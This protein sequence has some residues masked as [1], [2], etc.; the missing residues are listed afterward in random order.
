MVTNNFDSFSLL[1]LSRVIVAL[2]TT[3]QKHINF[4]DSKLTRIL[5]P[6]LSGNAKMAVICCA[7]PSELYLEETRSTLQFAS[8]AKLVKTNAQV[9]EVLDD[10]S[11]IRRLQRE[12]A[13]ARRNSSVPGKDHLRAL[14]NKAAT[15]GTAAVEAKAKLDRLKASILNASVLF[16]KRRTTTEDT[17]DHLESV[18][19]N[20]NLIKSRKRRQSDGGLW[21]NVQSPTKT[22]DSDNEMPRTEPR[23]KRSKTL[24]YMSLSPT[25]EIGLVR[26]ALSSRARLTETLQSSVK[27]LKESINEIEN[28]FKQER[29]TNETKL[30][31]LHD[32]L[33]QEQDRS[34]MRMTRSRAEKEKLLAEG[35]ELRSQYEDLQQ[36]S[37]Q[38]KDHA[39]HLSAE[40]DIFHQK[41]IDLMT[42][43]G[44]FKEE[45]A[46]VESMLRS[47]EEKGRELKEEFDKTEQRLNSVKEEKQNNES[48][49]ERLTQEYGETLTILGSEN[50]DL[51]SKLAFSSRKSSDLEAEYES[52]RRENEE[53]YHQLGCFEKEKADFQSV[54]EETSLVVSTQETEIKALKAA[55]EVEVR[56]KEEHIAKL[57]SES[58]MNQEQLAALEV[59]KV[60]LESKLESTLSELEGHKLESS[61]EVES[62]KDAKALLTQTVEGL[63]KHTDEL[64]HKSQELEENITALKSEVINQQEQLE[65]LKTEKGDIESELLVKESKFD[66][67][68]EENKKLKESAELN[69]KSLA[70]S[71]ESLA[72]AEDTRNELEKRVETSLQQMGTLESEKRHLEATVKNLVQEKSD[73]EG[74]LLLKMDEIERLSAEKQ[75][76][77]TDQQEAH[78]EFESRILELSS[79]L[80]S[81]KSAKR[82]LEN[83]LVEVEEEKESILSDFGESRTKLESDLSE[84]SEARERL[85]SEKSNLETSI[86]EMKNQFDFQLQDLQDGNLKMQSEIEE[87]QNKLSSSKS[88]L[89]R[90]TASKESLSKR[91]QERKLERDE[92]TTELEKQY[93]KNKELSRALADCLPKA[94]ET[95]FLSEISSLKSENMELKQLLVSTNESEERSRNAANALESECIAK[96]RELDDA[97][98]RLSQLEEELR[99]SEVHE[100]NESGTSEV[101]EELK[102]LSKE[103]I[104]IQRLLEKEKDERRIAEEELKTR[105]G[106]EQRLLINEAES[107]MR[108]LRKKTDELEILLEQ[109][110]SEGYTARQQVEELKD[111]NKDMEEKYMDLEATMARLESSTQVQEKEI[112]TLQL[113][114]SKTKAESFALRESTRELKDK[115]RKTSQEN[116]RVS[117][118]NH[119][120]SSEIASLKRK[121]SALERD[122][123]K[124]QD[125][126]DRME[127]KLRKFEKDGRDVEK[128]DAFTEL[129][130][131]IKDKEKEIQSLSSAITKLED[132]NRVLHKSNDKKAPHAN[133]DMLHLQ[134]K[135]DRLKEKMK[136]KDSRIKKLEA[137]RLTKEQVQSIK[138]LKVRRAI[139]TT[140]SFPP[141]ILT[142]L[143][144]CRPI[145]S[146]LKRWSLL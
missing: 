120:S 116:E 96:A 135:V 16:G 107:R 60:D 59:E 125:H 65:A 82:E 26:E 77:I 31:D 36:K 113:E 110:E 17:D 14:E 47:E 137:V 63:E 90:E 7:T 134:N 109:S 49:F 58:K 29:V 98:Y 117:K 122:A 57:Q 144:L 38:L 62:L 94:K 78:M 80:E 20:S 139:V 114:L 28:R 127:S 103:K 56:Q 70:S 40:N 37:N 84:A 145:T 61:K 10:R 128:S 81:L 97:L 93:E 79:S 21:L 43:L 32:A 118:D 100:A 55:A 24:T 112:S 51:A 66:E 54:I 33:L 130:D 129:Q 41:N 42:Q 85:E 136:Q 119:V 88:D 18:D 1:T 45:I 25:Q 143:C 5:Q 111:Q 104:E 44:A 123:T 2:G 106:E 46:N 133:D 34:E 87:L 4:R 126:F 13:E 73:I 124:Q 86:E 6:S 64:E 19:N 27:N 39:L 132:E 53:L 23:R 105:M 131:A 68:E 141:N 67:I 30:S 71:E 91:L 83:K 11:I 69:Q 108:E 115:L 89:I 3:N 35:A 9:N 99:L 15:A 142:I 121:I 140:N 76:N 102:A 101:M 52:L 72:Q 75:S 138:K 92:A 146:I 12:L 8:R 22:S 48:H 74:Q 95:D 50:E